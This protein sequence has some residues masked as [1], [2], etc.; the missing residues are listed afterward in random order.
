MGQNTKMLNEQTM[1]ETAQNK[2]S[3]NTE[4]S[5]EQMPKVALKQI[6]VKVNDL[7]KYKK[8]NAWFTGTITSHTGKATGKYI[9]WYNVRKENNEEQS[10][11]LGN[12]EWERIR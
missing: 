10:V 11:D 12:L 4:M 6:S 8:D 1:H 9:H 2:M 5:N 3:Q 7:I